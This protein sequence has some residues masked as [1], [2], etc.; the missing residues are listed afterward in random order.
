[1][2]KGILATIAIYA[3]GIACAGNA[4]ASFHLYQINELFSNADGSIQFIEMTVGAF[5]ALGLGCGAD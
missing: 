2:I 4:A 5:D 1:M 3:V